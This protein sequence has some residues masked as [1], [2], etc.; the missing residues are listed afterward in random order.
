MSLRS[1]SRA[2]LFSIL[3]SAPLAAQAPRFDVLPGPRKGGGEVK[4]TVAPGGSVQAEKDE[5]SIFEGGVA[6]EYQDIK[7]RA[8]KVTSNKNRIIVQFEKD[9]VDNNVPTGQVT[10]TLRVNVLGGTGVQE[11]LSSSATVTVSK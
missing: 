1:A 4:I 10:L 3:I 9:A 2:F 6:I 7:L 5:Y 8:E 11:Q